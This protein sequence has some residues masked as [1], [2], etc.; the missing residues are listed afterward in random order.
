MVGSSTEIAL[1]LLAVGMASVFTILALVAL[2]SKA[3]I[4]ITNRMASDDRIVKSKKTRSS[5]TDPGVNSEE[6]AAIVSAVHVITEGR[7]Q[8]RSLTKRGNQ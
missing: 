6:L 2:S 4:L 5:A 1:R 8:I 3:L 7:G